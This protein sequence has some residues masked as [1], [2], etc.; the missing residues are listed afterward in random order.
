MKFFKVAFSCYNTVCSKV[1]LNIIL[2]RWS[3]MKQRS[4]PGLEKTMK[5]FGVARNFVG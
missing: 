4:F 3:V 1:A 5:R 2:C